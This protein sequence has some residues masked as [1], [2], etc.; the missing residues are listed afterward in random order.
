MN[1]L[2]LTLNNRVHITLKY[3]LIRPQNFRKSY[4]SNIPSPFTVELMPV[5]NDI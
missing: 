3:K 1:E 4:I 2:S 5:Y